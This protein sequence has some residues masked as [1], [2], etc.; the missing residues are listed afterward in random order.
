[1]AAT[2]VAKAQSDYDDTQ[3]EL[4]VLRMPPSDEA[5]TRAEKPAAIEVR[6]PADAAKASGA[7][8]G[9]GE[10]KPAGR[11]LPWEPASPPEVAEPAPDAADS[12]RS[13]DST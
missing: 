13:R 11:L 9:E 6:A 3:P 5:A 8:N 2:S 10:K 7:A 1:M 4:P 12:D